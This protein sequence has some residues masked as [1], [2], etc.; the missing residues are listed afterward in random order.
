MRYGK[1]K[2]TIQ[3]EHCATSEMTADKLTKAWVYPAFKKH[4][5]QMGV[6]E[7]SLWEGVLDCKAF[8]CKDNLGELSPIYLLE[9]I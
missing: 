3:V 6:L 5:E 8:L 9:D 1:E 7:L 2:E 4:R